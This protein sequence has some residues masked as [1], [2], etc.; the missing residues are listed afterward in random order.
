M[1]GNLSRAQCCKR[2]DCNLKAK[3]KKQ[4][5]FKSHFVE[6]MSLPETETIKMWRETLQIFNKIILSNCNLRLC[7]GSF[8]EFENKKTNG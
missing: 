8:K 6:Y 7:F 2:V 3:H 1:P 5:V 4:F